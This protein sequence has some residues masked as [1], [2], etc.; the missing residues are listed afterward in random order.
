MIN[1]GVFHVD[2][3]EAGWSTDVVCAALY[4]T[5]PFF[6]KLGRRIGRRRTSRPLPAE[7]RP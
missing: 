2:T 3:D 4:A 1:S 7:P 6:L 5:Y